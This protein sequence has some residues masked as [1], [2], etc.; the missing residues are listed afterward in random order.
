MY[1]LTNIIVPVST[2]VV[3]PIVVVWIIFRNLT[4]KDNKNAEIVIKA[5]ENQSNVDVDKLIQDL[6]KPRKTSRE[7]LNLRL[8]RGCIFTLVGLGFGIFACCLCLND[9]YDISPVVLVSLLSTAIGVAYL[10]VYFVSRK[11][12]K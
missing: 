5:I 8:L 4:N 6:S 1:W 11:S 3:L 9:Y 10:I 12:E 2:C 7:I